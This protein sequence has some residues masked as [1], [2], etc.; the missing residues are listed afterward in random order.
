MDYPVYFAP[1]LG[2]HLRSLRKARRLTQVQLAKR[3]GVVQS[4]V[5]AMESKPETMSVARLFEMLT[6]L[7]VELVLRDARPGP[8]ADRETPNSG[9][10]GSW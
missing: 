3:L 4:R 2:A 10:K 5:A 6:A 7:D 1:Q 9:P 8:S